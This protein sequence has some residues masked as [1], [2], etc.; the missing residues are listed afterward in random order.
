[1]I[2]IN[3]QIFVTNKSALGYLINIFIFILIFIISSI[4]LNRSFMMG[5]FISILFLYFSNKKINTNL[6]IKFATIAI[7]I[8]FLLLLVFFIKPASSTGRI[9]IYKI[10]YNIFEK[11]YFS[12]IGT[13]KFPGVYGQYQAHYFQT[14]PATVNSWQA[15]KQLYDIYNSD[16]NAFRDAWLQ[17]A[18]EYQTDHPGA[19]WAKATAY[20]T[21]NLFGTAINLFS[22]DV[23]SNIINH[24]RLLITVN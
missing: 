7:S 1:M 12:G 3:N 20:A 4:A 23:N 15:L 2:K 5:S 8:F 6:K 16:K 24:N 21:K 13:G 18:T 9:F 14:K 11:N 19:S 10:S 22:T 17:V